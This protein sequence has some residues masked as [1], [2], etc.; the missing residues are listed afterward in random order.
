MRGIRD[1]AEHI[2]PSSQG[3]HDEIRLY[4]GIATRVVGPDLELAGSFLGTRRHE[5]AVQ[6][7]QFVQ[8]FVSVRWR[9]CTRSRVGD[10]S[11]GGTD[12]VRIGRSFSR[13]DTIDGDLAGLVHTELGSF[14]EVREVRLEE[15]L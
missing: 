13:D 2:E 5:D 1:R 6:V 7:P 15:W 4:K 3:A 11:V 14:D 10:D 9:E 8:Q 12:I